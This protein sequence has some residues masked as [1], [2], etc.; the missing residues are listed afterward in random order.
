MNP[1]EVGARSEAAVLAALTAT[2]KEV[3]L[4]FSGHQRYDLAYEQDDRLVKV[5]VKT[6]RERGG[7]I[8]FPTHNINRSG[9]RRD[10]RED[11]DFFGVYCYEIEQVFM[12]PVAE[13]PL[14]EA[15]LRLR[16]TKNNQRTRVRWARDYLL[17]PQQRQFDASA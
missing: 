11:A 5:Q 3:L 14:R 4:P 10:Y 17:S 15:S 7:V 13:V 6:G 16:D 8:L 9:G 1:S 12:I 2:G